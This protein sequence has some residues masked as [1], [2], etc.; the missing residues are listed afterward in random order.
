MTCA[1]CAGRVER[2]LGKIDGVTASVN[3]ATERAVL[4]GLDIKNV[5][6]AI[7]NVRSAGYDAHLRDGT[8]DAW[9]MRATEVRI[10]SLRTR[11]VLSALLMIPLMDL[12][13]V[14]AL[15]PEWR[16][17]GWEWVCIALATPIVTWA[18]W[19]FHKATF[20]NLRHGSVSMD[21]LVSLA[22]I[23]SYGWALV[24]IF[25]DFG[26]SSGDSFW[27]VFGNVSAG[28]ESFYLDV[29][30]GMTTFQLAGRYFETRSRRKAGDVLNS[31]TMLAA[32]EVRILRDGKTSIRPVSE[33]K[34]RDTFV[35][36]PGETVPADGVIIEG[37]ASI[38]ASLMTGETTPATVSPGSRL[39]AGTTSMDGHLIAEAT[40]VGANT[41]LSQMAAL[42]EAAQARKSN[43]QRLADRIINWFVP[44][45]IAIAILVTLF[46]MLNGRSF[47]EALGIGIAVLVI[48]CPCALGLATPTALMV[49]IGRGASLGILIKGQD[50]L[51]G[52]GKV[53]TILLDKT[54]TLTSGRMRVSTAHTFGISEGEL[55]R[56]AGSIESKSEH[57]IAKAVESAALEHVTDFEDVKD[58]KVEP[59]LGATG[60][61]GGKKVLAGNI[62]LMDAHAVKLEDPAKS[63]LSAAIDSGE[64]IVLIAVESEIVGLIT[65]TDSVKR[66]AE[67]AI[68]R[69]KKMGLET[70]LLTGDSEA[71]GARIQKSLGIDRLY[72]GVLP[73]EKGDV[74]RSLQAEGRKVAMVGDGINDAVALA[75]ADLGLA[76]ANGTDIAIKSADI[77]LVREDLGAIPDAIALSRKTLRTIHTNLIWAFG[78]N[79]AAIPIA[80]VGL[81]NPL[82]AAAAMSLSSVFVIYNSL[83]LQKA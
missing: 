5:D 36:F 49:G 51:E 19:P 40:S 11:L 29:A 23:V 73:T 39:I 38:D 54:G 63:A 45:V 82:I 3:Y 81:L 72:A 58:F 77:V 28:T 44:T 22:I 20:R 7:A 79:V 2:A 15:V 27:L 43:V 33:L 68:S 32:T 10:N 80:A 74:V 60:I 65:L 18:A 75:S 59:G 67:K 37:T 12:T 1:A 14:L 35:V 46:W 70:V 42:A 76:V 17:P 52:S 16:F 6:N 41:Q 26:S 13:I 31:L 66:G 30:A 9:S 57:S 47:E 34:L 21:T 78:Y 8:D 24:T 53:D 55:W 62:S 4:S 25:F 71:A 50:A 83:R 64:T 61:I 56:L 69:L 48:A